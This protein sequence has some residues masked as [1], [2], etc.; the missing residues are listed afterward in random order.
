MKTTTCYTTHKNCNGSE[1]NF[2]RYQLPEGR[3]VNVKR[4]VCRAASTIS[5]TLANGRI[6]MA[7]IAAG[8]R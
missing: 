5:Y 3:I 1:C 6:V 8:E 2:V 7:V 4:D